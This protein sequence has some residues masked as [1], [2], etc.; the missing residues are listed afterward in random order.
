MNQSRSIRSDSRFG[1]FLYSLLDLLYPRRCVGCGKEGIW[2]CVA[3]QEQIRRVQTPTCFFCQR[4]SGRGKTCSRCR[5]RHALT[6]VVVYGYH[7]GVLKDGV[8][9]LKYDLI[10]ELA[11]PLGSLLA[12]S[13]Y[14]QFANSQVEIVPIPLHRARLVER[15]FNQSELLARVI[16]KRLGLVVNK[17]LVRIKNVL[18]QVELSGPARRKNMTGAFAWRGASLKGRTVLLIDDVATTGTTLNEAARVLRDAGA[19]QV[20]GAVVAKG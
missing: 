18:P 17:G 3:C 4:V 2:L 10:Q 1:A 14:A 5:P 6:G 12:L 7:E 19:R 13:L 9:S 11:E 15:G 8:H 20:W 16:A